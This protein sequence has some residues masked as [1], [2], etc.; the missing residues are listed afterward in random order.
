VYSKN[1]P[2]P[3]FEYG[4]GKRNV[5]AYRRVRDKSQLVNMWWNLPD[6]FPSTNHTN[7]P[8][9]RTQTNVVTSEGTVQTSINRRGGYESVDPT[10]LGSEQATGPITGGG[11]GGASIA[12]VA[13]RVEHFTE[14][15]S[16][17]DPQEALTTALTVR[18]MRQQLVNAEAQV[19]A[20]PRQ[21]IQ[22]TPVI[23]AD[24]DWTVDYFVGDVV[25]VRAYI[26]ETNSW[27]FNGT[28]RIYGVD[29]TIDDNEQEQITVT[30]VPPNSAAL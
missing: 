29:A 30:T 17:M 16:K 6:G 25:T 4:T 24:T 18:S 15:F 5:Q 26:Q 14:K 10:D 12:E 13:E 27:R 21:Q 3:V 20:V 9:V 28:L 1:H 19:T 7:D 2:F 8:V 23:D 22:F 11:G